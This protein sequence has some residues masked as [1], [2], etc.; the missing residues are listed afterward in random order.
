[1]ISNLK[2]DNFYT[3]CRHEYVGENVAISWSMVDF[4]PNCQVGFWFALYCQVG[5][6]WRRKYVILGGEFCAS[7]FARHSVRFQ[8]IT[9][10]EAYVRK[11]TCKYYYILRSSGPSYSYVSSISA[12]KRI[13]H[14]LYNTKLTIQNNHFTNGI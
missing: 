5:R 4:I 8:K 10:P 1:M 3:L 14:L 13:T 12:W 9:F 11:V 6:L 2:S 7:L